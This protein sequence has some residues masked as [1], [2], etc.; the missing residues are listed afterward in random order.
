[1][2]TF[3]YALF[4]LYLVLFAQPV[5]WSIVA[6]IL[7]ATSLA[8]F[9]LIFFHY[10]QQVR[11]L[12]SVRIELDGS[13]INYRVYGLEDVRISRADITSVFERPR[14]LLVQTIHNRE[15]FLPSGLA[16]DGDGML[17][18]ALGSWVTIHPL[19]QRLSVRRRMHLYLLAGAALVLLFANTVWLVIPLVMM[20]LFLATVGENRLNRRH[21][22]EPGMARLYGIAYT[23]VI[24][25][26]VMKSCLLVTGMFW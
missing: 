23:F 7:A 24:F 3:S 26:V 6:P 14:G 20:L 22:F 10:R 9:F 16:R 19:P 15:V 5:R 8:Y 13:G 25:A 12:Y 4:G 18:E 1:M 21:D 17:R 11:L 2:V